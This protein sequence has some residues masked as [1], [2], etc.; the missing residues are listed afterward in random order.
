MRH[1]SMR[2]IICIII[3]CLISIPLL[4]V[5]GR[6]EQKYKIKKG[7]TLYKIARNHGVSVKQIKQA[8]ALKGSMLKPGDRIVVP[9]KAPVKTSKRNKTIKK[10]EIASN[11]S[12]DNNN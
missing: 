11:D 3:L 10:T 6:A 9:T 4:S 12:N 8:N 1:A 5:E 7:D 2:K